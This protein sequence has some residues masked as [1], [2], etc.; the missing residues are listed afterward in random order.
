M[1][2]E[3]VKVHYVTE[4]VM[5]SGAFVKNSTSG[6]LVPIFQE[7]KMSLQ[8]KNPERIIKALTGC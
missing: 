7:R 5:K 8:T 1:K 6:L 4:Y 2:W 3:A